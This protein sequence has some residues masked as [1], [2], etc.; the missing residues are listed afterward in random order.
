[1]EKV[2]SREEQA[3][4]WGALEALEESY[5]EPL[6]LFYR[7]GQSVAMVFRNCRS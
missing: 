7:E 6:V 2:I 3:I 4:V 5:R 1:M